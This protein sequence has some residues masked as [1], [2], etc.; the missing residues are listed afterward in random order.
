MDDTGVI[1]DASFLAPENISGRISSLISLPLLY[2][3]LT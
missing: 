1:P 2:H 3:L